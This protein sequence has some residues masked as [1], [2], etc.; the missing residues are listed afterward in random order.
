MRQIF[1][2]YT[3]YERAP[4]DDVLARGS[5]CQ[6][7]KVQTVEWTGTAT[8]G[9]QEE[10]MGKALPRDELLGFSSVTFLLFFIYVYFISSY[11]RL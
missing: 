3:G 7:A 11:N 10:T 5:V 8:I 6:Q 2:S 4:F 1:K 9:L